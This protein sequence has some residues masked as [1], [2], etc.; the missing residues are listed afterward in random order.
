MRL[1]SK[2]EVR[3]K[4]DPNQ[5]VLML[6]VMLCVYF[7]KHIQQNGMSQYPSYY[8]KPFYRKEKLDE[9]IKSGEAEKYAHIPTRAALAEETSSVSHDPLVKYENLDIYFL[10]DHCTHILVVPQAASNEKYH[11][12]CMFKRASV[13]LLKHIFLSVT[14]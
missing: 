14:F 5:V 1:P 7:R 4:W 9:M 10:S 3:R 13:L 12:N 8:I 11:D 6:L 2:L